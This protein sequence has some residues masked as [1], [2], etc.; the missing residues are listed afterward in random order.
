MPDCSLTIEYSQAL[1]RAVRHSPGAPTRAGVA[2]DGV[3]VPSAVHQSATD[4]PAITADFVAHA[5]A[6]S[7][8]AKANNS[9]PARRTSQGREFQ[10][11]YDR[12]WLQ[13][14]NSCGYEP[15]PPDDQRPAAIHIACVPLR[16]IV[17]L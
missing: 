4:Q 17:A 14:I 8:A 3:E 5:P 2:R 16:K 6:T 13:F 9:T 15:I 10:L 12:E 11:L 1:I 7:N